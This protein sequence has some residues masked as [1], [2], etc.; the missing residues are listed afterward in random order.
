MARLNLTD[1]DLHVLAVL[2]ADA[3]R[4]GRL[5]DDSHDRTV[6]ILRAAKMHRDREAALLLEGAMG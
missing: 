2:F 6:V 1:V 5:T 3:H 4:H